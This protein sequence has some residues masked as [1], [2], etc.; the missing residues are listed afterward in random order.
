MLKNFDNLDHFQQSWP[1]LTIMT[2]FDN[3]NNFWQFWQILTILTIFTIFT[4]LFFYNFYKFWQ[5]WSFLQFFTISTILISFLQCWQFLT[6]DDNFHNSD[7]CFCHFDNWKDNPGDLW[8]LRHWLQLWQLTTWIMTTFVTWQLIVTLDSIRNSCD[9]FVWTTYIICAHNLQQFVLMEHLK[10]V[11]RKI[12][13]EEND[14]SD[15]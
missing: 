4:I 5:F 12:P 13:I 15:I 14:H 2:I 3:L 10:R 1:F 7:N 9:V 11:N 8:N 6:I